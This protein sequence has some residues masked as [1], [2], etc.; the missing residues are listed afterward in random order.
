MTL[1]C[2]ELVDLKGCPALPS[3]K[4]F[5]LFGNQVGNASDAA[6]NIVALKETMALLRTQFPALEELF[7]DENPICTTPAH[8]AAFRDGLKTLKVLNGTQF[9]PGLP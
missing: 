4:H 7:V 5:G 3:L 1:S 9:Y 8:E 2:N 6:S